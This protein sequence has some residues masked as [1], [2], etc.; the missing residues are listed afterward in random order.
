[1]ANN[2]GS[3]LS[4]ARK[5]LGYSRW[6]DPQ[7]GTKYGRWYESTI[8]RCE[9]NYDFGG[10]G[11]PFCAM[12]VSWVFDQAGA[13]GAGIPGA[14]CPSMLAVG[15]SLGKSVPAR[16]AIAGD[17]VYFDWKGDGTSDHVGFV[18]INNGSYLQ[19]IEGN[20]NNGQ[21]ARRTRAYS[22]VCGVIRPD[23]QG[24]ASDSTESPPN[25]DQVA[26]DGFWG[27]STSK[28]LQSVLGTKQDGIVPDQYEGHKAS[29]PGLMAASWEWRAKTTLG[30]DMVRALQ[31]KIGAT[32]D[33]VAGP[34]TFRAMQA[35]LGTPQD[36][37]IS[38]PSTCVKALQRRLNAGTF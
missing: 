21:V 38:N 3:V 31:R 33:G 10:S 19:C 23:Y 13:S 7:P 11:V 9:T 18:E 32:V 14:Y 1:M 25:S 26:V 12:F 5:E 27:K 24:T 37:C 35:Y 16:S 34:K 28:K 17:V 36:G 4:I 15:N 22:T 2:A 8:D 20:T 29:N 30:S 6:D